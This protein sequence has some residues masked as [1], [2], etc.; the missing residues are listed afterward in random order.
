MEAI[1]AVEAFDELLEEAP[2]RGLVVEVFEA[3]DLDIDF[4]AGAEGVGGASVGLVEAV[5]MDGGGLAIVEDGLVGQSGRR[6]CM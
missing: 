4:I 6:W 1:G 3:A 2:L 5:E